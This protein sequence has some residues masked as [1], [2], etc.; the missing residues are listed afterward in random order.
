MAASPI[1]RLGIVGTGVIGAGWTARALARGLDVISTDPHPEAEARLRASVDNAWP[2]LERIGLAPG[3]DRRRLGFNADLAEAVA[4]ADFIQESA[5]EVIE[6]KVDLHRRIDAA[7]RP[8]VVIASSSSGLLPSEI[9]AE[10]QHPERICIGHPFNP[11]YILPLV[12][13]LGGDKTATETGDR[14]DAFYK[15]IGMKVVRVRKEVPGYI[16]DRLQEAL[17]REA[18][19]LINDG[20]ATT[21]DIDT[22]LMDG[23]GF[24]YAIMGQCMTYHMAGGDGG[25]AHC[26]EQFGPALQLPWTSLVAPELTD[27][28]SRRLIDGTAKQAGNKTVKE[29]ELERDDLLIGL[30][31]MRDNYRAGLGR[32]AANRYA[33]RIVEPWRAG[34]VPDSP[35]ANYQGHVEAARVDYNNHM[36]EGFYLHAFGD[37]S[38]A[39]FRYIGVDEAYRASGRTFFTVE[40]HIN[41]A[42][43]ASVGDLLK[44]TTQLLDLNPKGMHI[45][46]AMYDVD[47]NLL[48]TTEQVVMHVNSTIPK[49]MPMPP[50]VHGALEAILAAHKDMP[51][52]DNAGRK[53]GLRKA[54]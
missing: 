18:L 13:V 40:S 38:D 52:P 53:M 14:A 48:A 31:E 54:G 22:T 28:L 39:L 4:D 25:M 50:E 33:R 23:P 43:E 15:S 1:Q 12:E 34:A 19:H 3:A 11:V 20:V 46:N 26:L 41:Y 29:L 5:P 35:L 6:I 30:F 36:S 2:A 16:C 21:E 24:R 17:W 9:Q 51:W 10:C 44:Y 27:E 49:T 42:R 37:A 32:H 8:D 45:F 7:A 47:D